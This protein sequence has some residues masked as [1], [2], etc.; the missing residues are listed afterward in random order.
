[1]SQGHQ[2]TFCQR[3][4]DGS[5]ESAYSLHKVCYSSVTCPSSA[6]FPHSHIIPLSYVQWPYCLIYGW[7]IKVKRHEFLSLPFVLGHIFLFIFSSIPSQFQDCSLSLG[8]QLHSF[9]FAQ[10]LIGLV[11]SSFSTFY[12]LSVGFSALPS[13]RHTF[14]LSRKHLLLSP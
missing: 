11:I 12:S 9:L 8:P 4:Y 6:L 7:R 2:P 13:E 1:M 3:K 10:G 5:S 14:L